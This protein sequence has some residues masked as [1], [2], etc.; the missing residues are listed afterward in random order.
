MWRTE[1]TWN[2]KELGSV[3]K[4]WPGPISLAVFAA[5]AAQLSLA[6]QLLLLWAR[7]S[8]AV[9][10]RVSLTLFFYPMG[11]EGCQPSE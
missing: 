6:A 4:R 7:C 5:D 3:A 1:I 10:D 9:R 2:S 8:A 11:E